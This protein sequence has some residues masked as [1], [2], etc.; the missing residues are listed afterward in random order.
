MYIYVMSLILI[1]KLF[2]LDKNN[3]RA[4]LLLQVIYYNNGNLDM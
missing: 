4:R 3:K 2:D 1:T